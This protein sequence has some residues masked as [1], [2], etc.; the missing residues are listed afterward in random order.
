MVLSVGPALAQQ[1]EAELRPD[2]SIEELRPR[3]GM[4]KDADST[5]EVRDGLFVFNTGTKGG[6]YLGIGTNPPLQEDPPILGD[7]AAWDGRRPTTVEARL[8]VVSLAPGAAIAA[9][10]N[11]ANGRHNYLLNVTPQGLTGLPFDA[12]QFHT[13][14]ITLKQGVPNLYVDGKLAPEESLYRYPYPRNALLIGDISSSAGG[15]SEWEYVRWTNR[16]ATPWEVS[17]E[18]RKQMEKELVIVGDRE[19]DVEEVNLTPPFGPPARLPDGR[20]L[21]WFTLSKKI[22]HDAEAEQ[23]VEDPNFV[24]KA[25]ARFSEDDGRTWGPPQTLFE[26]PREEGARTE[27]A[28]LVSRSGAVHLWGLNFFKC[29]LKFP[30]DYNQFHSDLWHARSPDGGKTW[31]LVQKV[32]FGYAYTGASNSAIQLSSGRILVPISRYSDR[33]TG[34]FVTCVPY[35]DDDGLTWHRPVDEVVIDTGGEGLESGACEPVATE[36]KDGRVW[37]L[38]RAQDGYQWETFSSDGGLHWS[39]PV[40]SRFVCTNSPVA[41]LRLRDGRLVVI[42]NNCGSDYAYNRQLLVAALSAD[43][44]RTWW[45]YRE[46][47]R[48]PENGTL[49]YPYVTETGD[50]RVLMA[51][52]QGTRM[53]RFDPDFLLRT[54]F[55]EDFSQSLGRWSQLGTDGAEA[56]PDPDGGGGRML[57]LRKPQADVPAGVCL[58]FP[59]GVAGELV[60]EVRLEPGSQGA[61]LALSDHYDMP[62]LPKDG[63]YALQI[64]AAGRLEVRQADGSLA[65]TEAV[66]PAGTWH[67]LRLAWDCAA[68]S[69]TLSLDGK[70][71]ATM[72]RLADSLGVCYLRLRSTAEKTDEAGLY[73]RRVE[74]QARPAD[75]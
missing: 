26:F 32:D 9:Q 67:E 68:S 50:G 49:A 13:Y 37:M 18:R 2:R 44:G 45:G 10:L 23:V 22:T 28:I 64:T 65:P 62:G 69:A 74:T 31:P 7:A 36:L 15:V 1:W 33:P 24:Q 51:M 63:A 43:E 14:R 42:W 52:L 3:V 56:A 53:V 11:V 16:E 40:H 75:R 71:A 58:N 34:R 4:V 35:S 27:G 20:I 25:G 60:M 70:Q 6:V 66:L 19:G 48:L 12:T 59:F 54:A 21:S 8:R 39:P 29:P 55:R 38:I 61:S 5:L 57:W 41:T 30:F 17:E 47:A 72:P 73:V 46:V